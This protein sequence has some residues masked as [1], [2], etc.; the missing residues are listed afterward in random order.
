E[1]QN[2]RYKDIFDFCS[3]LQGGKFN[4]RAVESLI[5]CGAFDNMGA[6]RKQML[7]A[8]PVILTNIEEKYRRTM[9][10]QVG[11]F[12]LNDDFC[13]S[14]EMPNVEEYSK[15]ELLQMEKEMTGLYLSGHPMDRYD[16]FVKKAGCV[17]TYDVLEAGNE[18]SAV[19]DGSVVALCGSITRISVKQT[20]SNNM[21]M[22]F[23]TLE[24]L[25]G[26]VEIVLFPKVFAQCSMLITQGN[27]IAV[28]GTVSIEEEKEPKILVN[29]V[30]EPNADVTAQNVEQR[31]KRNGLFLK[32]S[33]RGDERVRSASEILA[34]Y[35]GDFPVYYFFADEKKYERL[36]KELGFSYNEDA[37]AKLR[38]LLGDDNVVVR[39]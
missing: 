14:F 26:T 11:L 2:G 22:A 5:R 32:F 8:L 20:R 10:G 38:G 33:S 21:N 15:S 23:V 4:R 18:M 12:D 19:K 30:I 7:N 25:Y 35:R 28:K 24:D 9:Y 16:G 34:G 17:R 27:V 13:D 39:F 37:V 29:S 1:R 3:R 6:N 31:S 36:K